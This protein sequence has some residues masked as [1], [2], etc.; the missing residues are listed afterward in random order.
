MTRVRTAVLGLA[1]IAV[2][3]C[4]VEPPAAPD[5]AL[6][7]DVSPSPRI[8]VL[9]A[10]LRGI[11][12]PDIEPS[13][14]WGHVQLKLTEN[15][16]GTFAARWRGRIFNPSAEVFI[17]GTAGIIDPDIDPILTFFRL[18]TDGVS[19]D[20][21]DFDSQ[22]ITDEEHIPAEFALAMI[23]NP[24]LHEARIEGDGVVA[25]TFG[26]VDPATLVGFNPQPD[27][28]TGRQVRCGV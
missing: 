18:G 17:R 2:I 6:V 12:N 13:E 20:I 27:P 5:L 7:A 11:I 21:I 10:Q 28:P 4:D 8:F 16:D 24:D 9:N 14:A 22:G 23:I 19:C 15:A 25:G 26:L 1:T 3:G